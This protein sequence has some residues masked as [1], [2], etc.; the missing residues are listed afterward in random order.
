MVLPRKPELKADD[1]FDM[2]DAARL[3]LAKTLRDLF[4]ILRGGGSHVDLAAHSA[5]G[6]A[7]GIATND[8]FYGD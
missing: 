7:N 4:N 5:N 6:I 2:K 1:G 8:I 3:Q